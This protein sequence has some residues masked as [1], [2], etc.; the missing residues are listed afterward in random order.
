MSDLLRA[1]RAF[2]ESLSDPATLP[3]ARIW[4]AGDASLVERR[5]SIY[6]ANVSAATAKALAAKA[7]NAL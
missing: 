3:A 2:A 1:Q 5:L 7:A 4:L 6:R